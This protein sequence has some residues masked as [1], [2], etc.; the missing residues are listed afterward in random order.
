M[1]IY[2]QLY[3]LSQ[4]NFP[5]KVG[6]FHE[7]KKMEHSENSRNSSVFEESEKAEGKSDLDGTYILT[8]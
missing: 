4:N 1:Q 3:S 7:S 6:F 5:S 8:V 2:L